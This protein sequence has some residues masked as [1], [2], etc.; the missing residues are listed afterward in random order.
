M[1]IN[2]LTAMT[3]KNANNI[4]VFNKVLTISF[5]WF[6]L[7]GFVL[8]GIFFFIYGK[9]GFRYFGIWGLLFTTLILFVILQL[10]LNFFS[11]TLTI[12]FTEKSMLIGYD[13]EEH[14]FDKNDVKGLYTHDYENTNTSLIS[15]QI[16]FKNGHNLEVTDCKFSE[17]Y[18]TT[19]NKYLRN[20]L[21]TAQKELHLKKIEKSTS[22]S[23]KK[24]GAYWYARSVTE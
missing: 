6:P 4:F 11:K 13:G 18:D 7:V 3:E 23:I 22:R 17:K 24:L 14:K 16:C 19:S 20:F 2:I 21:I 1:K 15:F 10:M 12:S 9:Y 5:F 8:G